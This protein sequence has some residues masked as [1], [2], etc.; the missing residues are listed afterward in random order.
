MNT[1]KKKETMDSHEFEET[2]VFND[3]IFPVQ[4][5]EVRGFGKF[6]QFFRS[7]KHVTFP[8][9]PI[10]NWKFWFGV[11]AYLPLQVIL[12]VLISYMFK[13]M[14]LKQLEV[15][16]QLLA[17]IVTTLVYIPL[18]YSV[19]KK[20]LKRFPSQFLKI[21]LAIFISYIAIFI[22]LI[23]YQG[24]IT[25]VFGLEIP[26]N[27]N[28]EII[29]KM[30]RTNKIPMFLAIVVFG[31][32]TEEFFFRQLL[33]AHLGKKTNFIVSFF[34]SSFLFAG[35]HLIA[36]IGGNINELLTLPVYLTMGFAFATVYWLTRNIYASILFHMI[37]NSV[38]FFS[39]IL[40]GAYFFL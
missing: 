27:E 4:E 21:L 23:I 32:I 22:V 24:L 37:W 25:N 16:I 29:V 19:L 13:G 35:A 7:N 9:A 11:L 31:P 3:L 10:A 1:I 26:K 14:E 8:S 28:Q 2:K 20:D 12:V 36:S 40:P 15:F 6:V 5:E 39:V 18:L 33:F 38:S 30:V 17:G 34:I